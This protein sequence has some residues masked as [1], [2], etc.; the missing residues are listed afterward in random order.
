MAGLEDY[1]YDLELSHEAEAN[2]H[3]YETWAEYQEALEIQLK[4]QLENIKRKSTIYK[5]W[6]ASKPAQVAFN[7]FTCGGLRGSS[8]WRQKNV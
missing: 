2:A 3:G 6:T 7:S 8:D 4:V 5:V 1:F